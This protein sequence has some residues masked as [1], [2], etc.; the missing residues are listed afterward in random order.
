MLKNDKGELKGISDEFNLITYYENLYRMIE[1]VFELIN[2]WDLDADPFDMLDY[3][4]PS[5]KLKQIDKKCNLIWI[6]RFFSY[7]Y[8]VN[9]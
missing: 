4:D 2:K 8:Y 5:K 7:I 3:L 1:C 6:S 9:N